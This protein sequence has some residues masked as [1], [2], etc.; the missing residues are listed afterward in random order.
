M[1]TLEVD[2]MQALLNKI[3]ALGRKGVM[4]ENAALKAAAKP[5]LDD[6]VATTAFT[7]LSGDGRAS[8][9]ISNVKTVGDIKSVSIGVT[10]GD[11][12]DVFYLKFIEFGTSKMPARPFLA[13]A[14]EKNKGE[15]KRIIKDAF[16]HGLGL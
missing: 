14:F 6:A 12:S 2:G 9:K 13:P 5:M 8:L 7:D 16:K 15:A 4:I 11:I 1:A 10:K 3:T